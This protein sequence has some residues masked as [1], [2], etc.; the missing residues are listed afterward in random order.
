M[1]F[2]CEFKIRLIHLFIPPKNTS[3]KYV[4]NGCFFPPSRST[5]SPPRL[6]VR[7]ASCGLTWAWNLFKFCVCIFHIVL[8]CC[9]NKYY[10]FFLPPRSTSSP[11]RPSAGWLRAVS[12]WFW[13][14]WQPSPSTAARATRPRGSTNASRY[15]WT[16]SRATCAASASKVRI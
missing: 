15:R 13:S 6:F 3:F 4:A 8:G 14:P 16:R 1:L 5:S 7:R 9:L 2:L 12:Y 11:P 10:S